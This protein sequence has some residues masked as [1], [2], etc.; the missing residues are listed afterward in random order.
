M[1]CKELLCNGRWAGGLP[2]HGNRQCRVEKCRTN[3]LES[4]KIRSDNGGRRYFFDWLGGLQICAAWHTE[5]MRASKFAN[6]DVRQKNSKFLRGDVVLCFT[7]PTKRLQV[8]TEGRRVCMDEMMIAYYVAYTVFLCLSSIQVVVDWVKD[9]HE[10]IRSSRQKR[11]KRKWKRG[12]ASHHQW[13]ASP[14][15]NPLSN[16]IWQLI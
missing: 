12:L 3:F 1:L 10:H 6:N 4:R 9:W 7:L 15:T 13:L 8:R 5:G 2:S 16:A 11:N 14:L